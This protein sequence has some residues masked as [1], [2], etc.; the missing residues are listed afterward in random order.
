MDLFFTLPPKKVLLIRQS[1]LGQFLCE[2]DDQVSDFGVYLDQSGAR[3]DLDF[4]IF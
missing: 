1:C 3:D 4:R 2:H